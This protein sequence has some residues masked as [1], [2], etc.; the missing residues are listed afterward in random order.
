MSQK[1]AVGEP[2]AP[3]RTELTLRELMLRFGAAKDR[4]FFRRII[5]HLGPVSLLTLDQAKADWYAHQ[6]YPRAETTRK[7]Q[8]YGPVIRAWRRA[9]RECCCAAPS[10]KAPRTRRTSAPKWISPLAFDELVRCAV[11]HLITQMHVLVGT[12]MRPCDMFKLQWKDIDF[13][14]G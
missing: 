9:A 11:P 7:R 10:I 1:P 8:F 2:L 3:R 13:G 14:A 12:G 5:V 4:R 6:L